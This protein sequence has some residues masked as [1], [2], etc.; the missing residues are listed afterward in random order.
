[1]VEAELGLDE[2]QL[3][4]GNQCRRPDIWEWNIGKHNGDLENSPDWYVQATLRRGQSGVIHFFLLQPMFPDPCIYAI[5]PTYTP[6]LGIPTLK[7]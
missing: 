1:M 3:Y 2:F 5:E 6:V 7:K 4:G